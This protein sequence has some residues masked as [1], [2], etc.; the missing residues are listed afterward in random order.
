MPLAANGGM[1]MNSLELF[2][3]VGG[4]AKGLELAGF[5]HAA[6]IEINK[7]AYGSLCENFDRTKVVLGDVRDI[8]WDKYRGI[9]LIAGGPPCQPFS[10][11]GK[12]RAYRDD[13][14][15]FPAAINGIEKLRPQIFVFENV[16]GLLRKNFADYFEYIKLRLT[17]PSALPEYQENWRHHLCE[18]LNLS[19][20][21]YTGTKYKVSYRLLNAA[22]YGV[23]QKRERVI[24]VGV[25]SDLQGNFLF[26]PE[27]HSEDRLFWDMYVTQDYW[28]R[29]KVHPILESTIKSKAL[30]QK[31]GSI[32]PAGQPWRTIRDT[33][34]DLPNPNTN[35]GLHDH[36][37]R[38]G[39]KSY[40]GHTGSPFDLPAKTI[41][42]GDHGVPGGENMIRFPTGEIRYFTVLEAKRLQTFADDFVVQGTWGEAIR[43]IGNAVPVSLAQTIGTA[44]IKTLRL[45][46]DQTINRV[47]AKI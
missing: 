31:Y 15:M 30:K 47:L 46:A 2:S 20:S 10:L 13:R 39:A 42:A 18:L 38:G 33:L 45:E 8:D 11:G 41:K 3:G 36:S 5:N 28:E 21:S 7:H 44:L 26:P 19:Y 23:P 24:I 27:T 22:N 12:H 16:K 1:N 4:L 40:P 25:R 6:L 9:D 37:F 32:C 34:A 43:Q 17:Y 14:D 29:H 35:H